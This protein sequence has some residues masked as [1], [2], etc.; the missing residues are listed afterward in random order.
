MLKK[1]IDY[2]FLR[3]AYNKLVLLSIGW[4]VVVPLAFL[5]PKKR[6]LV[7]FIGCHQREFVDNIKYLFLHACRLKEERAKVY[8]VTQNTEVLHELNENGLPAILFPTWKSFWFLL[9]AKIAVVGFGTWF[10]LFRY[11]M[12][13]RSRTVQLWHG[14]G[15][16]KIEGDHYFDKKKGKQLSKKILYN[17][18][19]KTPFYDLVISTSEFY[20]THVFSKAMKCRRIYEAG[21]PR[22]DL[23]YQSKDDKLVSLYTDTKTI[24]LVK[25]AR[26]NSHKIIFFAP[27]FREAKTQLPMSE[28]LDFKRMLNFCKEN[29]AIFVFKIHPYAI[30]V[31][32]VVTNDYIFCYNYRKDVNPL[33]PLVDILVT[34]YSSIYTD[35]L[36]LNRPILFF[37]YDYETYTACERGIQFEYNYITP[38][39]KCYSYEELQSELA[40]HIIYGEDKYQKNREEIR[41]LA[42]TYKDGKASERIWDFIKANYLKD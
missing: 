37:P 38:G 35:F 39:P 26:R 4:L 33:L 42:F 18:L 30:P 22:N 25:Q 13:F 3:F 5:I 7:L 34:D 20:T 41:N 8:F 28:V 21:Y 36:L 32:N 11:Y 15:F 14:I 2:L 6:N 1:I 27:T 12:L 40:R 29:N 9:R 16:K 31:T 24:S 23:F 10:H 17:L 19:G